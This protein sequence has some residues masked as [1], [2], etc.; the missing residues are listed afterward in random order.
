MLVLT[1]D[2]IAGLLDLDALIDALGPAVA[3]L[4]AGRASVPD[5]IGAVVPGVDGRLMAIPG[6]VPPRK[7]HW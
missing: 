6:H 5:R 7:A 2:E 1:G 3:D 4:S